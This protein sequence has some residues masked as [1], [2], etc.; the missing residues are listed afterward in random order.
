MNSVTVR[1]GTLPTAITVEPSSRSGPSSPA[2]R[3]SIWV[4]QHGGWKG[5]GSEFAEGHESLETLTSIGG[6][7]RWYFTCKLELLV[8]A[9]CLTV[10]R[11]RAC[12]GELTGC[13]TARTRWKS[14]HSP[15]VP[16]GRG[17]MDDFHR[18]RLC[19]RFPAERYQRGRES[20][21]QPRLT[22]AIAALAK[23]AVRT[24]PWKACGTPASRKS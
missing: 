10:K 9:S 17:E 24:L 11:E 2:R 15:K 6:I 20:E 22:S 8:N 14:R 23:T 5:G 18:R 12:A 19:S 3:I 7:S 1:N 16:G 4:G 21:L 13:S